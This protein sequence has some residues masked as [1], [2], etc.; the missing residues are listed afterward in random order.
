[1][2]KMVMGLV[3]IFFFEFFIKDIYIFFTSFCFAEF[4]NHNTIEPT[5]K[6]TEP[7]VS[8]ETIYKTK[9]VI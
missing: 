3:V 7:K 4:N 5:N 6:P 1:M 8:D 9:Q 2:T